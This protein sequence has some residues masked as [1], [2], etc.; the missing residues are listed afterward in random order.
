MKVLQI[1]VLLVALLCAAG[2]EPDPLGPR[3]GTNDTIP[4]QRVT[5][6]VIGTGVVA[7]RRTAE[8]AARGN[9]AYTSTYQGA[10][11]GDA[12]KVWNVAGAAPVLVDSLIIA[13]VL[14]TGDIQ[15]SADGSLLVVAT[16]VAGGSI[17]IYSRA[18]SAH[19]QLLSRFTNANTSRGVHTVKLG[20][21]NGRHYAFL[22][23]NPSPPQLVVV[24]ITNPSNP[25]EVLVKQM[26]LPFVHDVFVRDGILFTALWHGGLTIWDIGGAGTAGA[27]PT[28]PI[29]LGNVLTVNGS[30]HNVWWYHAPGGS[31]RYA[32]VG[33]EAPGVLG[34]RSAGDV[35]VVDVSDLRNPREVAL[36]NVPG[37]GP[38]NFVMD[39]AAGILYVAYYDAG[40]RA[41][42][43]TGDLGSC[44]ASEK[45]PDGRCDL[46]LMKREIGAGLLD[47][48]VYVWGV[49]LV[50]TRVFASDMINGLY[51]LDASVLTN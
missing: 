24:D 35:H 42:D 32:F 49:A 39:E 17:V 21:V 15:I 38:H 5:L 25:T 19:P 30:V 41:L 2:C 9:W 40:V 29:Q 26:G 18:D 34:A 51:V 11:S 36:F 10:L 47:R 23:V 12:I 50:G 1:V 7:E 43:V 22:S 8:V 37:S 48:S 44:A 6:P 45:A 13:S 20:T 28:N 4:R 16:E 33:E 31:K 3:P 14:R 46:G 27:S